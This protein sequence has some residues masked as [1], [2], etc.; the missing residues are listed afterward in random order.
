MNFEDK[1]SD[2]KKDVI[3]ILA[4]ILLGVLS[5]LLLIILLSRDTADAV[6]PLQRREAMKLYEIAYD[7]LGR[8]YNNQDDITVYIRENGVWEPFL[9]L[10]ASYPGEGNGGTLLLR[11]YLIQERRPWLSSEDRQKRV[12]PTLVRPVGRDGRRDFRYY[13][14][15]SIDIWLETEYIQ[16]FSESMQERIL[17]T[18]VEV[19][20]GWD[21][22]R[23]GANRN[24]TVIETVPRRIFLLSENEVGW[25]GPRR[26]RPSRAVEGEPI[27]YFY[28][29]WRYGDWQTR[30]R[31]RF[32]RR[33]A[34]L[35]YEYTGELTHVE[36]WEERPR[37]SWW[38]RS[39]RWTT[40][41]GTI[42]VIAESGHLY[43][44]VHSNDPFVRPAFTL[45]R[46]TIIE[47][48]EVNGRHVYVIHD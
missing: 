12:G 11:R 9:V 21:H 29:G 7:S 48:Y 3:A 37:Y 46:D 43:I 2:R 26:R 8:L 23:L 19:W 35:R 20:D 27:A 16:V 40:V 18:N 13:P 36:R 47:R 10:E 41:T 4:I 22:G 6:S 15:N 38:L 1:Q 24:V 39:V 44:Q 28:P 5:V 45:P 14:A 42:A 34:T 33:A 31:L 32:S 25:V 30:E 17:I